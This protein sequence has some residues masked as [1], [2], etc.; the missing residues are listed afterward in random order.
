MNWNL[1]RMQYMA[2]FFIVPV[3]ALIA[4]VI[5][6]NRGDVSLIWLLYLICGWLLWTLMEYIIHRLGFHVWYKRDHAR[7]HVKPL[8]L[9]GVTPLVSSLSLIL[10]WA[11]CSLITTSMLIGGVVFVGFCAGYY[12]YFTIH[13][14]IHHSNGA[15]LAPLRRHHELHH[16]N[17]HVNYGVSLMFWDR[18]FRTMKKPN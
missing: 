4:L 13:Y 8:E 14:L 16:R 17:P 5:S 7:H 10:I 1:T 12:S 2:D 15:L 11:I 3:L 18:L 9:I 6:L